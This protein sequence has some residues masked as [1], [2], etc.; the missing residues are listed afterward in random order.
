MR[1]SLRP[2][3]RFA[4]AVALMCCSLPV[5]SQGNPST[6]ARFDSYLSG[7]LLGY[8]IVA[9]PAD[10]SNSHQVTGISDSKHDGSMLAESFASAGAVGANAHVDFHGTNSNSGS[11]RAVA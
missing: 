4:L 5:A 11:L 9:T 1:S 6:N 7:S 2:S 3:S 10:L 8:G